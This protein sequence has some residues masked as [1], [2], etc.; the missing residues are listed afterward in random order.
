MTFDKSV[1]VPLDP[2]AT[3][4]LVTQPDRLRR[5]LTVAARVD[6][7]AGGGY[8]WTVTPGHHAAG[9]IVDVDP[10]KRVVYTF[11]WEEDADLP[12]GAS[13]VTVT[14]T[15][16][17]AGTEVRLVHDGLTDE[18]AA[19]HAVGWNHFMDRLVAAGRDG[20]AG[21][22]EW[23]AAPDPLDELLCAEATLAVLQGVL[24]GLD[25]SDLARQTPCSEYTVAQLADHLL[26]G[27]TR[28]GA[29]AG[30]QMPQRDLDTPL[31]T[32]VADSADAALEA[33]RR[34]GLEGTVELA[35]TQLPATAAVGI[36]SL[37]FL[38]HAWDFA[39]ATDR[40]VVVSEPVCSYVQDLAGK[41]VT[42]QLRAGRFAEPVATAADVDAL[43]RLIAFTGRQPAVVQTSAN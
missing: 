42:P 34:K 5:W 43:G 39:M 33:W 23:A 24:R 36:L 6:L 16:V 40:H 35:S 11:G 7:R 8:Q 30:A 14:L 13:T 10:G 3:F 9:T 28:I 22:D 2:D 27:M 12:P 17:D 32:Q 21:P 20:D 38:V 19:Q 31:E 15:P 25:S 29:A 1:V 41:I 4:D 26:T 18:Q 37:E